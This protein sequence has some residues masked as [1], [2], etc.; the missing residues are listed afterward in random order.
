MQTN[1]V[2]T[3]ILRDEKKD[4]NY[5]VTNNAVEIFNSIFNSKNKSTKSFTIIGNYGTGK[6]TFLWAAEKNL[7]GITPYFSSDIENKAGYD[8]IKIIGSNTSI[9]RS[10]A[11]YLN[12]EV[13]INHQA[14]INALEEKYKS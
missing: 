12:I 6:S 5:V 2:S 13:N 3:N 9:S 1:N 7:S 8:F 10:F 14:I 4:L 11:N